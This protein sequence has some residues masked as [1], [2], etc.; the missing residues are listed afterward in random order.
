MTLTVQYFKEAS[1][2]NERMLLERITKMSVARKTM[3]FNNIVRPEDNRIE[4]IKELQDMRHRISWEMSET[5]EST[6]NMQE[7]S[8]KIPLNA[9]S[10]GWTRHEL[11]RIMRSE[12]DPNQRIN[13][14]VFGFADDDDVLIFGGGTTGDPETGVT[15]MSDTTNNVTAV[16]TELDVS[17]I[18]D[19]HATI[20]AIIDELVADTTINWED[21]RDPLVLVYTP[22]VH[23]KAITVLSSVNEVRTPYDAVM[24]VLTKRGAPGSGI[25]ITNRLGASVTKASGVTGPY[26]VT[27][28]T[29]NACLFPYNVRYGR[30]ITSPMEILKY[31]PENNYND[32]LYYKSQYRILPQFFEQTAFRY[33]GTVAL[34]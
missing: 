29:T 14:N 21:Q 10:I 8:A 33:S 22:D 24:N 2:V 26:T 19:A 13:K 30:V 11:M 18:A 3:I 6:I 17:T 20:N 23:S 27:A 1:Q 28:G 7:L 15:G 9:R 5:P 16:S 31:G 32:G 12:I 4:W 34:A 25:V